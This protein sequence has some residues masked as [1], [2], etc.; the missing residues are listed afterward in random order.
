MGADIHLYLEYTNKEI[1][2]SEKNADLIDG[3]KP[4]KS[5][6]YD[7][8]GGF[9]LGRNYRMF[10]ILSKGVRSEFEDGFEPKGIPDFDNLGYAARNDY[11]LYISEKEDTEFKYCTMEQAIKWCASDFCNS[12][13]YYRNP[14]DDKPTWVSN[15]D[16]HS[17][18]W[19][20]IDEYEKA[21]QIYEKMLEEDYMGKYIP[22]EYEA[23]LAAMKSLEKNGN[24]TRVVFWFDN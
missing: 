14:T 7:F 3:Y 2:D 8:G 4:I 23:I 20:T 22:A 12:K 6:W 19:L 1:L 5:Y 10:G 11:S 24:V 18:S 13:L 16:W 17:A 21:I 15:P 9:S